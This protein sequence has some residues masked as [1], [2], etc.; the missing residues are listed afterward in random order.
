MKRESYLF[1][2]RWRS[3]AQGTIDLGECSWPFPVPPI[4]TRAIGDCSCIHK[5]LNVVAQLMRLP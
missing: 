4:T 5:L 1:P 2:N 3:S